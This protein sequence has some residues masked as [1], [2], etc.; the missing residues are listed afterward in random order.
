MAEQPETGLNW[1]GTRVLLFCFLTVQND[2]EHNIF[3][4]FH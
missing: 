4:Q 2:D 3:P 1:R